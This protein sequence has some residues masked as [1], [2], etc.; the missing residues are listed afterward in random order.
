LPLP[1]GLHNCWPLSFAAACP[2]LVFAENKSLSI[3]ANMTSQ[4]NDSEVHWAVRA[5]KTMEMW[6][7]GYKKFPRY[8]PPSS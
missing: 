2:S 8:M 7:G 4:N 1:F 5:M 3:S 6:V